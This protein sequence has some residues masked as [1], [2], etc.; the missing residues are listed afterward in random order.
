LVKTKK[1]REY[2]LSILNFIIVFGGILVF[3]YAIKFTA[4]GDKMNNTVLAQ[5]TQW[6]NNVN[7]F[8]PFV[9]VFVGIATAIV[10]GWIIKMV[11]VSTKDKRNAQANKD[12]QQHSI[13]GSISHLDD[14]FNA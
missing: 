3:L 2:A 12:N 8:F 4:D 11:I 10:L 6:L 13:L 14:Y 1:S 9:W 5:L 7:I